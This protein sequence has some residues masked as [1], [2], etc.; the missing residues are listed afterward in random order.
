MTVK[1]V[2]GTLEGGSGYSCPCVPPAVKVKIFPPEINN[3]D[4]KNKTEYTPHAGKETDALAVEVDP[5]VQNVYCLPGRDDAYVLADLAAAVTTCEIHYNVAHKVAPIEEIDDLGSPVCG[6]QFIIDDDTNK[7]RFGLL[8][9]YPDVASV[10]NASGTKTFAVQALSCSNSTSGDKKKS[11]LMPDWAYFHILNASKNESGVLN[12]LQIT[13]TGYFIPAFEYH[14]KEYQAF[15]EPDISEVRI[16]AKAPDTCA[17][18]PRG[19]GKIGIVVNGKMQIA[20]EKKK[21]DPYV[22]KLP[23]GITD[24]VVK[25]AATDVCLAWDKGDNPNCLAGAYQ[26]YHIILTRKSAIFPLWAIVAIGWVGLT[27]L[28]VAAFW[29]YVGILKSRHAKPKKVTDSMWW[30]YDPYDEV[31]EDEEE[32]LNE[33]DD[34][35][36]DGEEEKDGSA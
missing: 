21:I 22:V 28:M 33:F 26:E 35:V 17:G 4:Q 8:R 2:I 23:V 6:D 30:G 24:I 11:D 5:D 9:S 3:P 25:V 18:A 19:V 29:T 7:V 16:I 10:P 12:N 15:V 1:D 34:N 27:V 36:E 20:N 14:L 31:S 13:H 32:L